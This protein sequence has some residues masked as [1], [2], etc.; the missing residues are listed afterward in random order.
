MGPLMVDMGAVQP[1]GSP[2]SIGSYPSPGSVADSSRHDALIVSKAAATTWHHPG[3]DTLVQGSTS[4]IYNS[5]SKNNSQTSLTEGLDVMHVMPKYVRE[6]AKFWHK[7]HISRE[8]AINLLRD[9]PP[10]TFVVRNSHSYVGA[11]GLALK[12]S[13][14]PPNVQAKGDDLQA[15][16]VRHFLIEST[17]KGVKLKGCSNEPVFGSLPALIYQHSITPL[18]LPCKLLLPEMDIFSRDVVDSANRIEFSDNHLEKGFACQVMYI[19]SVDTDSLTGPDA[20]SKAIAATLDSKNQQPLLTTVDMR[21]SYQGILV[22]DNK[23][24]IFFRRHYPANTI[25]FC[26]VDANDKRW[27]LPNDNNSTSTGRLFGFVARKQSSQTA[28]AC[29]LFLELD[30]MYPANNIVAYITKVMIGQGHFVQA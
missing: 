9:K 6:T 28:N 10:G 14:L 21:I 30:P 4:S 16:L 15:N 2:S 26:G 8:E 13:Q 27:T 23:H 25:T 3:S 17:Q 18:S 11:Y 22:T 5:H 24:R 29:H 20:L 12:V 19:D 1:L 7:S